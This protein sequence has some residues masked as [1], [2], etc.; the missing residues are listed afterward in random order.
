MDITVTTNG[1]VDILYAYADVLTQISR[2]ALHSEVIE[3]VYEVMSRRFY[4][5]MDDQYQAGGS[6]IRHMYEWEAKKGNPAHRLWYNILVDN[7]AV[8][9]VFRESR[10]QVPIDP[11]IDNVE[12]RDHVFRRKAEIFEKAE[13]VSITP[14]NVAY[15]R[16]Y[17]ER[18][19]KH[20]ASLV[21]FRN[22]KT[23]V[24]SSLGSEIY[25]SGGREFQN[26]FSN[27]FSIFWSTAGVQGT[28]DLSRVLHGSPVFRGAVRESSHRNLTIKKLT[29]M[30]G[31]QRGILSNGRNGPVAKA[32]AKEMLA[33]IKKELK[34][35]GHKG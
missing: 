14:K 6:D 2:G 34:I 26:A 17:D 28:A 29:K 21:E 5:L 30:R 11:R 12:S 3:S 25:A 9:Y 33:E 18:P 35:Y 32:A 16:W 1:Q 7:K 19:Y 22:K 15:L 31:T 4:R 24:V 27:Q 8:A 20:G 23:K 10:Q 13:S